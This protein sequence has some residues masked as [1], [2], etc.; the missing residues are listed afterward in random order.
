LGVFPID[1]FFRVSENGVRCDADGIHVGPTPLL[2]RA[3]TGRRVVRPRDEVESELAAIYGWSINPAGKQARLATAASAL[4]RGDAPLAA[5][6][7]VL[8]GFPDPPALV[9]DAPARGSPELAEQLA[10]SGLLKGDWDSDKH[11]RAG[12]PP[13]VGWFVRKP[14]EGSQPGSSLSGPSLLLAPRNLYRLGARLAR[15]AIKVAADLSVEAGE[16]SLRL[17]L[18]AS[19]VIEAI[20]DLLDSGELNRGDQQVVDQLRSSVDPP[21]T[22]EELQQPPTENRLGYQFHHGVEQNPA[23]IAKTSTASDVGKFGREALDDPCN[24][25]WVPTY[26]HELIT[27]YYNSKDEKD[28]S[29]THR[30]VVN[31]L[32]FAGQFVAGLGAMRKYGV[33]K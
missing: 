26:K 32:D 31:D 14:E 19:G 16:V 5:I 13:N 8:L 21:R 2:A 3:A 18:R 27:D 17:A 33:L 22:L 10:A 1:R 20:I 4:D 11:P 30:E 6:A 7:A 29:R 12:C 25:F 24:L 28:P 23:N 9:K 15:S